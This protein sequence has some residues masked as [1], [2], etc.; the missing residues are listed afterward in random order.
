MG[1]KFIFGVLCRDHRGIMFLQGCTKDDMR[2]F[3]VCME[4]NTYMIWVIKL[5]PGEHIRKTF[6]S[7]AEWKAEYGIAPPENGQ[8]I[9][10]KAE[11]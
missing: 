2:L 4:D 11:L 1:I 5:D 9:E 10:V 8:C 7:V 3:K 6:L